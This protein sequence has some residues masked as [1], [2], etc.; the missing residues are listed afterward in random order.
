LSN[1]FCDTAS[2]RSQH[3]FYLRTKQQYLQSTIF[4]LRHDVDEGVRAKAASL[5]D[6]LALSTDT[7]ETSQLTELLSHSSE[8]VRKA[9]AE[10]LAT[11][12]KNNPSAAQETV[13]L[14]KTMYLESK[15][16]GVFTR[17]G[18]ALALSS[19]AE[20]MTKRELIVLFPT[21]VSDKDQGLSDPD[22]GVR[23]QMMQ[24]GLRL[25]ELHGQSC[26]E[27]LTPMFENQ[28]NKP[29]SGT[30]AGDLLKEGVVI[31]LATLSRF[32]PKGDPKVAEV[33]KRLLKALR[34]PS[35]SVQRAAATCMSPLMNMLGGPEEVSA[36]VKEDMDMLLEGETYGDRRGGAFGLAGIVKG[37]GISALKA[38]DIMPT[39]QSAA[40]DKKDPRR[41][42]GAL[43][44][45]ECLS[46]KL[47]R[48]FEPYV[49]HILPIL[50]NSCGDPDPSVREAA[51]AAAK[52]V[53]SQLSGQGVKLV[54]PALLQGVEDRTWRTKSAAVDL[55]GAM[56][57]CAPKQLGTCLPTIVPVLAQAVSDTHAKVREG[58]KAALSQVGNVIKNPEINAIAITLISSLSDPDLTAK[59]LEVVIETTF[60]NAVDAPSLALLVPVV[61]VG[62]RTLVRMLHLSILMASDEMQGCKHTL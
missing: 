1:V 2:P 7:L 36:V 20:S 30:Y 39:L 44:G 27:L 19:I 18:V 16:A 31:F 10:S 53:M 47:G 14:L 9:A 40:A 54:M 23:A 59:A 22:D 29:D 57:Y 34:T 3:T 6:A 56:A 61:Q 17:S 35:E 45:F 49:I 5:Y 25:I 48:L 55:L 8:A 13:S 21:L 62:A 38:H 42:E 15:G 33:M 12:L 32:L 50:L 24:A 11:L 28:L 46:E 43:F 51:D 26:M 37:L 60:V 58:A 4:L 52:A 41:R